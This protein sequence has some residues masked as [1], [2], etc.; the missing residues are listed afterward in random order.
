MF[1][2]GDKIV[3]IRNNPLDK[4]Y[5]DSLHVH[6]TYTVRINDIKRTD[7]WIGIDETMILYDSKRFVSL[8]EFRRLKIEEICSK[9]EIG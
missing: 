1:K 2:I 5:Y 9:L 6:H 7:G 4:T 8:V 3:L